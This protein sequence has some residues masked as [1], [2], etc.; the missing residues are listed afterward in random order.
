MVLGVRGHGD[1]GVPKRGGYLVEVGHTHVWWH[2]YVIDGEIIWDN[3]FEPVPE[4]YSADGY[5]CFCGATP[6]KGVA[7]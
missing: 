4:G 2:Y 7:P 5:A 1:G 6:D 3:P